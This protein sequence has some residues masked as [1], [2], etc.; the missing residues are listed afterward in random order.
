MDKSEQ[1][2]TVLKTLPLIVSHLTQYCGYEYVLSS[3]LQKT[4]YRLS[5]IWPISND[6]W[7]AISYHLLSDIGE[8]TSPKPVR[9]S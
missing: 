1:H 5:S 2:S 9:Y 7:R 3:R 6:E 4:Q 8:S